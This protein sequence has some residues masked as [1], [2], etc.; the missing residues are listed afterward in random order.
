M[1]RSPSGVRTGSRV[2]CVAASLVLATGCTMCPD[3]LDYAGPVPNGSAPQ[4]DFRARSN[5]ILPMGGVAQPWPQIVSTGAPAPTENGIPT[6]A[7]TGDTTSDD[8]DADAAPPPV[9]S[10]LVGDEPASAV[11][12]GAASPTA[13]PPRAPETPRS[14]PLG[15]ASED[16]D[17]VAM[18]LPPHEQPAPVTPPG[19]ESP[20]WKRR[21]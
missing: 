18:L 3:P 1:A 20:G 9:V 17:I 16:A 8:A 7:D 15:T 12:A 6:L 4:N 13:T 19:R 14:T 2:R 5:G 21:R 10:V 11:I